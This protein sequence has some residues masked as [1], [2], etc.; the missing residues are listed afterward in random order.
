MIKTV[1][2]LYAEITEEALLGNVEVPFGRIGYF[3]WKQ[4]MPRKDVVTWNPTEQR[5]NE[6]QDIPGFQKTV[7]RIGSNW[8]KVLK[9]ASCFKLG[10]ENPMKFGTA[11][12][13]VY[14]EDE[15]MENNELGEDE[16]GE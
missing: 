4:I 7:L 11:E 5:Y 13:A 15:E 6:P 8:A 9:E 14:E 2:D 12:T 3:S 16:D 10:E 1:M